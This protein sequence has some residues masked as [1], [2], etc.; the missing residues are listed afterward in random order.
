MKFPFELS[1]HF[2]SERSAQKIETVTAP[3]ENLTPER[4]A[5]IKAILAD[6]KLEFSMPCVKPS[7]ERPSRTPGQPPCRWG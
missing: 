2:T 7:T 4:A 1:P 3:V 6:A 5:F